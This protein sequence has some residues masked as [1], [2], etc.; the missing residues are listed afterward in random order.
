MNQKYDYIL[1][2]ILIGDAGTGKS[3][4]LHQFIEGK[5]RSGP[6]RQTIGVEFGQKVV[7][8]NNLCLKLQIWDT[9][10]QERFRSV[11]RTY[12]RGA[13]GVMIVY[14]VG[15]RQSFNN[16][17]NW[18]NDAINLNGSGKDICVIICGNKC[19]NDEERQVSLLEGSR[20]ALEN[21]CMFL[22]TS[23]LDGINIEE[24]FKMCAKSILFKIES[25][26]IDSSDPKLHGISSS[27][28]IASNVRKSNNYNGVL[29]E[30]DNV[31]TSGC[32][33]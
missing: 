30:Q 4:I 14:D 12:Y 23:A 24:A 28:S 10:G 11:T 27:S 29:R 26:A 2:L 21:N 7:A 13:T 15:S 19:D 25:N 5:F 9:A 8:V 22:E 20:F 17:I 3:C 31:V 16:V 18:Y 32:L 1:K 6:A 33:C